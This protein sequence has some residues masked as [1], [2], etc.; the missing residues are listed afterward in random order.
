MVAAHTARNF[1]TEIEC[2]PPIVSSRR[3]RVRSRRRAASATVCEEAHEDRGHY[4]ID[5]LHVYLPFFHSF[6]ILVRS[7]SILPACARLIFRMHLPPASQRGACP[8]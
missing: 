1:S 5:T 7:T 4:E 8:S 6:R 2:V 3:V